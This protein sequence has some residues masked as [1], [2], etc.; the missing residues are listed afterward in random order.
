MSK[1]K[2]E[3]FG[4]DDGQIIDNSI[5]STVDKNR[6]QK[7]NGAQPMAK[8]QK[9][10]MPVTGTLNMPTFSGTNDGGNE[11]TEAPGTTDTD[12]Q[13]KYLEMQR[14]YLKQ[15]LGRDP[16]EYDINADEMYNIYR[17]EA[18]KTAEKARRDTAA[19][20]AGLTGGYG[21]TYATQLGSAAYNDVMSNLDGMI[22][23]LYNAALAKYE[24]EGADLL[25]KA[26]IAGEVANSYAASDDEYEALLSDLLH[27]GS[28]M[29]DE[30]FNAMQRMRSLQSEWKG[31]GGGNDNGTSIYDEAMRIFA[32]VGTG[33]NAGIGE[34]K[35]GE[36]INASDDDIINEL[37]MWKTKDGEKLTRN[38]VNY[39]LGEIKQARTLNYYSKLE[40]AK[41]N[42]LI[43]ELNKLVDNEEMDSESIMKWLEDWRDKSG[44]SLSAQ[45][46]YTLLYAMQ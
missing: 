34:D 38:D 20:A 37:L 10:E 3:Y 1:K 45:D 6:E 41:G 30:E 23:E 46:I 26:D 8:E 39:L 29:T 4:Y 42:S 25:E 36:F 9:N 21:S 22:P 17:D 13:E 35:L 28:K 44:K 19:Q 2:N 18:I 24:N 16:F 40:D 14:N 11:P 15:Y 43:T 7:P 33:K 32:G 5:G 12:N 27:G 31:W